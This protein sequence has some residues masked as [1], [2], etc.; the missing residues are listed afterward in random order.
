MASESAI[1][2]SWRTSCFR[3]LSRFRAN[4]RASLSLPVLTLRTSLICL[5]SCQG[6]LAKASKPKC[7][8]VPERQTDFFPL[9]VV[10]SNSK[11]S[12][13]KTSGVRC[14]RRQYCSRSSL[15]RTRVRKCLS[16][17]RNGTC[18]IVEG[19]VCCSFQNL[20]E[21]LQQLQMKVLWD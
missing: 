1:T 17:E 6:Y 13:G 10:E 20:L 18:E 8:S 15:F 14:W 7:D 2:I 5:C 19:R 21:R 12:S 3:S 9:P 11:G 16:R 4:S